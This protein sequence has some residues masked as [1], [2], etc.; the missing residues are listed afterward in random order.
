MFSRCSGRKDCVWVKENMSMLH[1]RR[2][3]EVMGEG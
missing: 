2:L 1:V 3:V